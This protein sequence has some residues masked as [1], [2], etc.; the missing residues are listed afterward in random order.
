MLLF[1][2]DFAILVHNFLQY[3]QMTVL[4]P[5]CTISTTADQISMK[6]KTDFSDLQIIYHEETK[7]ETQAC[8]QTVHLGTGNWC[9]R[10][11]SISLISD[12]ASC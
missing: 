9:V 3:L 8:P 7:E 2:I 10:S 4:I 1:L 5:N 6:C 12:L 11:G